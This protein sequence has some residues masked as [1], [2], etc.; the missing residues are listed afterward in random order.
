MCVR[1]GWIGNRGY[2]LLMLNHLKFTGETIRSAKDC[3]LAQLCASQDLQA[4]LPALTFDNLFLLVRVAVF[5]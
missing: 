4:Y 3:T 2:I 1:D 5:W